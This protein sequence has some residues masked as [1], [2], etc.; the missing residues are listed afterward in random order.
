[1]QIPTMYKALKISLL[2]LGFYSSWWVLEVLPQAL[3]LQRQSSLLGLSF[4]PCLFPFHPL[5]RHVP[6]G[7]ALSH[8]PPAPSRP[9][10]LL[11]LPYNF[12]G[13]PHPGKLSRGA[14]PQALFLEALCALVSPADALCWWKLWTQPNSLLHLGF[15]PRCPLEGRTQIED[16]S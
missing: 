15:S 12:L 10:S 13:I 1:M 8:T 16:R 2:A 11:C 3:G 9:M 4:Q 14:F 6:S 7:S 5:P